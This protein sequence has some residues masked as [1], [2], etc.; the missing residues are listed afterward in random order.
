M[1]PRRLDEVSLDDLVVLVSNGVPEGRTLEYKTELPGP[2]DADKKEF[3]ADLSAFAN[4]SGGD[5]IFG[6]EARDGVPTTLVG[7]ACPDPDRERLRLGDLMRTGLEPRPSNIEMRWVPTDPGRGVL[8]VRVD[9]SWVAPHRVTLGGHDKFY[10][11]NTAGKHPM[12][13]DELRLAFT[14]A[15]QVTDR[16]RAF[17]RERIDAV[18]AGETPVL[19]EPGALMLF[20]IVPLSA[21]TAPVK[22]S[23]DWQATGLRPLGATG[24]DSHPT[25]EGLATYPGGRGAG[26]GVRTYSLAFRDGCIEAVANVGRENG[27]EKRLSLGSIEEHLVQALSSYLKFQSEA[28]VGPPLALMLSILGA[29][30]YTPGLSREFSAVPAPPRKPRLLFPE[31]VLRSGDI[32]TPAASLLKPVFDT[33]WNAFGMYGSISYDAAGRYKPR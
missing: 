13:T 6:M 14:L 11:R 30:D 1:I 5:L 4:A 2:R 8:L 12:N 10:I 29:Q 23:F 32:S 22:I 26:G 15:L 3:L 25:L 28:G 24:W 21:F 9:R 16:V 18:L 7:V 19:I 33:M 31:H 27:T 20:H 17:R